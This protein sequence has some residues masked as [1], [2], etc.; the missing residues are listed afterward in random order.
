MTLDKGSGG[1]FSRICNGV[2]YFFFLNLE[3]FHQT[4]INK[5]K[6]KNMFKTISTRLKF[7][8]LIKLGV[9]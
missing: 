4:M 2:Q 1:A 8:N 3:L 6:G 7:R 9:F 5:T